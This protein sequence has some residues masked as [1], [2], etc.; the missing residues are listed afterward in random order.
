MFHWKDLNG[1]IT[2]S[3]PLKAFIYGANRSS[4]RRRLVK[5]WFVCVVVSN[6]TE[7][8]CTYGSFD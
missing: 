2:F 6:I 8:M 3:V 4:S 7:S 5:R 1:E